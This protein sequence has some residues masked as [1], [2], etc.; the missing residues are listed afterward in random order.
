MEIAALKAQTIQTVGEAESAIAQVMQS[1][2]KYEYLNK[3]LQVIEDMKNS[4]NL[5]VFGENHDDP[6][7]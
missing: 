4:S 2:R 7:T 6:I 3:K 1:R 5:V